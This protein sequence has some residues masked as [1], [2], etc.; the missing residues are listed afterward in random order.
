MTVAYDPANQPPVITSLPPT[1]VQ[2]GRTYQYQVQGSD[3][4]GDALNYV[5]DSAPAGMVMSPTGLVTWTP[6]PNA[7]PAPSATIVGVDQDT[8]GSWSGTY[9]AAGYVVSQGTSPD[10]VNLPPSVKVSVTGATGV[11]WAN[12]TS[13]VRALQPPPGTTGWK[14][15]GWSGQDF[16]IDVNLLDG[17]THQLALYAV[18]WD[19]PGLRNDLFDVTDAATGA[20][21]DQGSILGFT[22]GYQVVWNVTG[23]IRI[24]V[25]SGND[26]DAVVSGLFVGGTPVS[27]HAEDGRGGVS[28]EQ[29]FQIL[30]TSQS[31]NQAPVITTTPPPGVVVGQPYAV[32]FQGSDPDGDALTWGLDTSTAP[33][34]MTIADDGTLL[35]EPT[36]G[37][38]G[39][40][41]VTVRAD[42]GAGATTLLTFSVTVRGSDIPPRITSN[43]VPLATIGLAYT[44]HV[45]ADDPEG[46]S[47]TFSLPTHPDG[48]AIDPASGVI[49]WDSPTTAQV[50]ANG[51]VAVTVRASDAEGDYGEESF[52]IYVST[53][54]NQAPTITSTAAT[55]W[56]TAAD[57]QYA[58]VAT[59]SDGD[60][61]SFY[62]GNGAP[63]WLRFDP[64]NNGLLE[65]VDP[66]NNN[67]PAPP[68]LGT[69]AVTI[70]A[71][72]PAGAT[73]TQ[74]FT[75][76]IKDDSGP[77]V[78]A[79]GG[80]FTI[81]AGTPFPNL[82][83]N[84][85]DPVGD[86]LTYVLD[87]QPSWMSVSASGLIT[88][89]PPANLATTTYANI[90]VVAIDASGVASPPRYFDLTIN[91]DTEPPHP[92]LT[93][94][95][96]P[97][98]H[99]I[100]PGTT[101]HFTASATDNQHV[102]SLDLYVD[103]K[104][105]TLVDHGTNDTGS[106][107]FQGLGQHQVDLVATDDAGNAGT[108]TDF[109]YV[110]VPITAPPTPIVTFGDLKDQAVVT[111]P[112]K[113]TADVT[114]TVAGYTLTVTPLN[115]SGAVQTITGTAPASDG[116][117]GTFDPTM[118]P[119]GPYSIQLQATNTDGQV[120]TID[121]TVNVAGQLKLGNFAVSFSDLSLSGAGLPITITRAYDTLN[122]SSPGDFGNGW[123]LAEADTNLK[124]SLAN[125]ADGYQPSTFDDHGLPLTNGTRVS[126]ILP[127]GATEGFTFE[128][129]ADPN[130]LGI[131]TYYHP[132][133]QPDP[134][135][136][137]RLTVADTPLIMDDGNF[138][139]PVTLAPYNPADP[140]FGGQGNFALTTPAG[141]TYTINADTGRVL[142]ETDRNGN[143]L[144]FSDTGITSS[145]GLSVT[146]QRDAEGRITAIT[147][148]RGH[149]IVYTYG[150]TGS[151]P[152][153]T[154]LT[155]VTDRNGNTTQF[156]YA[157][158][159][160]F[161]VNQITDPFGRIAATVAYGTD[162]RVSGLTDV[163]G[164]TT[165]AG[166][167]VSTLSATATAPGA[168]TPTT[169][170]F[171]T[172]GNATSVT[173]PLGNTVN[174]NY[175]NPSDPTGKTT[176][177][178]YEQTQL[179]GS[180]TITTAYAY[181]DQGNVTGV[182]DP[183]GNTT[184]LT[185]NA[186]GQPLSVTD[187]LGS[188]T[189][190]AYDANGNLISATSA[191]GLSTSTTYD[192]HGNV[193]TSS[194]PDGT[195]SNTYYPGDGH[196]VTMPAPDGSATYTFHAAGQLATST[197]A[198]GVS[199]SYAYDD[200]G[201]L[202][203]SIQTWTD[204]SDPANIRDLFT[205]NTYDNSDQP[206][207]TVSKSYDPATGTTADNGS[208]QTF[209]DAA[210]RVWKTLDENGQAIVTV[211]D[212][213]GRAIETTSPD[214]TVTDT[215]YDDQGRAVWADDP[216][217]P[218]HAT[219]GTQ[220]IYDAVGQV[221]GTER[222]D[223]VVITIQN[224]AN[225]NPTGSALEIH[226]ALLSST[227]TA[228]DA[229]GRVTSSTDAAGH[230]TTYQYD[231]A[232]HQTEVDDTVNGV[233]RQ[234]TSSYDAAG[235]VVA[236]TD[237]L[238]NTTRY[239][240]DDAGRLT[241]TTYADG[242]ST[243]TAYDSNGR[244]S[245]S[246]DQFGH[247]TDY[248][249]D[250]NGDL[251]AVI[252]PAVALPY[253]PGVPP[254]V[255]R[256][257]YDYGYDAAGN[258][259]SVTDPLGHTT[260][261]RY[262]AFGHKVAE[263]LP[264]GQTETWTY[265]ALGR[266]ASTTDFDGHVI[267]YRYDD[268]GR[269]IEKDEYA[270][271]TA[272]AVG[273]SDAAE[274]V[275]YTYDQYDDQGRR[276]DTVTVT[277]AQNPAADGTTTSYYDVLGN[278][279]EIDSPQGDVHYAYDPATGEKTEVWTANTDVLYAYDALGRLT[280]VTTVKLDGAALTTP[281]VTTC[282]YD[283]GN[284]L[285]TTALPNGTVETRSYDALGR[286]TDLV[287]TDPSGNV[288]TSDHYTLGMD[289]TRWSDD[290][291]G[292]RRVEY[293]YDALG[294]ITEEYATAPGVSVS[295]MIY[296]YDLAGNRASMASTVT[297][298][299]YAG[300]MATSSQSYTYDANDRLV[301]VTGVDAGQHPFTT[302]YT[303]DPAGN[304]L[305]ETDTTTYLGVNTYQI[306]KQTTDVWDTEDRLISATMTTTDGSTN[307]VTSSHQISMTYDDAG[308]RTSETVDGQ[309]TKYLNDPNQAYDQVLEEYAPGGVLAATY[310]RG[311]D[312]LFQDRTSAG[313]GAGLSFYAKDGLGSTRALTNSA[314]AVTDTY[315]YDAYGDLTGSTGTTTNEFL[316]AGYQFDRSLGQDYL[317]A[318]YLNTT[319]G[320][321]SSRDTYEG[322][323][324]N[325]ITENRY[326]YAGANPVSNVDFSGHDFSFGELGVS[327]AIGAGFNAGLNYDSQ[328]PLSTLGW[329]LA[330]G[331]IEGGLFYTGGFFAFKYLSWFASYA[332]ASIYSRALLS[333]FSKISSTAPLY[334]GTL[335]PKFFSLTTKAG[336]V[337]FKH[338]ATEH[339]AELAGS[340]GAAGGTRYATA[341]ILKSVES[342]VTKYLQQG[343][344]FG[345]K[346]VIDGWE[347]VLV[348]NATATV[349]IAVIHAVPIAL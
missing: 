42:D 266:L 225:G 134:G 337:F 58:V 80:P 159:H 118:L 47:L 296:T 185:Y 258:L 11:T 130:L 18:D 23:H 145:T 124:V 120:T 152:N 151:D 76:T 174:S 170:N 279:V 342:A 186:D 138:V 96:N 127:N 75:L 226:G 3:P 322:S 93:M 268:F 334:E 328:A 285:V 314:G 175:V 336:E 89:T 22:G 128:V 72:D 70:I 165:T 265:D 122:A 206:V 308:N 16:T 338:N 132:A 164:H 37:Q 289:G 27:L 163:Q 146:F 345:T 69:Y 290:Q 219:P 12:D 139:D 201:N 301:L 319:L 277:S 49:T 243:S 276:Y 251:T 280:T 216:H 267:A 28:D 61:V 248:T 242:T 20:I 254:S 39:T 45:V 349:K 119:D 88:G 110:E 329:N 195:T 121:R 245:A 48:M 73:D 104:P 275:I 346:V 188:T 324:S 313:G 40:H 53:D 270:D 125:P 239:A 240:Y 91:A 19:T 14:T 325:P 310:V 255:V 44:Y 1:S 126:L 284:N 57:Y 231:L 213:A 123:R 161:Y 181:D 298:Y 51:D 229:A 156:A 41:V 194:S 111:A 199:T 210:G 92:V 235:R 171:D 77:T 60:P 237:A 204:P 148:P 66:A 10:L 83:V 137:D 208:S 86:P 50:D 141:L 17:Q 203:M 207:T 233:A 335:I 264:L 7:N 177:Y 294:R 211:Y 262:D 256:P 297:T 311:L 158:D 299:G 78:A 236:S 154:D 247:E 129:T 198:R 149:A 176:P 317:R 71:H 74:S 168:D 238:G 84:A 241:M 192:D 29:N 292:E 62:L 142:T 326:L 339:L 249:Y 144:T 220:T 300:H 59:D 184:S 304:T 115:G 107:T 323:V 6:D 196:I 87:D 246:I 309:A 85:T 94:D 8:V 327:M 46:E 253:E 212:L 103:G 321:F 223:D 340:A 180:Q 101:V 30:L 318:R 200:D 136:T 21:L 169:L 153:V 81:L 281:L 135:V 286:L 191:S 244:K 293:T 283:L 90:K 288:I 260:T 157:P 97:A 25:S 259:V 320:A 252:L 55:A 52:E 190:L 348:Q 95:V 272:A 347:L 217:L 343:V 305:T 287:N 269:V 2:V 65:S 333:I 155:V 205:Q 113:I 34:G 263:T 344:K 341:L 117:F 160:A 274:V 197:D 108:F 224:D 221:T 316:F 32:S 331:A 214:G 218:G 183:L 13:D 106:F 67:A 15:G 282:A 63:S 295:T 99:T 166:V 100:L 36:E 182:T 315:T 257:E 303:Y 68:P 56:N 306:T 173:D 109:V 234:T 179:V 209:Y 150:A 24:E 202:V 79:L 189:S 273:V 98:D 278:L 147:D 105:V 312:L 332:S 215:V 222:Y 187:P 193:L 230:T 33:A 43:P 291:D 250:A 54:A 302:Q 178:L 271:A 167:D 4:D 227:M 143:S 9:G 261:Y 38:I 114:G 112:T 228:Y 5:L 330:K 64:A 162:G 31:H 26:L 102:S 232:G 35:W 133:F 116:S 172:L 82:Q 307:T 131:A 140:I